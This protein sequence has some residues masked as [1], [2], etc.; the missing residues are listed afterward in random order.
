MTA[1]AKLRLRAI[2]PILV[3]ALVGAVVF[4]QDSEV[5]GQ[6]D[7]PREV[8]EQYRPLRARPRI[9]VL[10]DNGYY[11]CSDCHDGVEVEINPAIREL[12]VHDEI[13]LLH[14]G[15]RFWCLTCHSEKDRDHLASLK[16]QPISFD[17]PFLLCGQCH[18]QRQRDYFR[19]AHGKRLESWRG[20]RKIAVCTECHNPHDPRI[21]PRKPYRPPQVRSGLQPAPNTHHARAKLWQKQNGNNAEDGAGNAEEHG[22]DEDGE[23]EKSDGGDDH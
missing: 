3:A 8:L 11:P 14:G 4:A 15:G 21:K 22:D 19:G 10:E 12:M 7:D 2:L 20:E 6:L 16:Q 13:E 17:E 23:G 18:F 5:P 1:A 9:P